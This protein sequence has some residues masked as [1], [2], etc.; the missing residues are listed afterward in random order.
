M[1]K[2]FF[3][4]LTDQLRPWHDDGLSEN[5]RLPDNPHWYFTK[6]E[7]L[8][9]ARLS[10]SQRMPFCVF[11]ILG[12]DLATGAARAWRPTQ[13]LLMEDISLACH[14]VEDRVHEGTSVARVHIERL[15]EVLH[16]YLEYLK[17]SRPRK[18]IRQQ[19]M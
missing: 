5:L 15:V 8:R 9:C 7:M 6:G 17:K 2:R 19:I 14:E 13:L 10:V 16:R 3:Y 12:L 18:A 11:K 1:L 4:W